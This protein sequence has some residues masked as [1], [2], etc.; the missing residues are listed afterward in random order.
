MPKYFIPGVYVEE[1]DVGNHPIPGISTSTF[2]E[3]ITQSLCK[4]LQWVL[5]EQNA[6]LLWDKVARHI[7][8]HLCALWASGTLKGHTTDQAFFVKC[9]QTTMT[10][11]DIRNGQCD[12]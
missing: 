4:E 6:P 1:L 2:S 7:H 11:D 3:G 9:D 5:L 10:Q 12:L 8:G